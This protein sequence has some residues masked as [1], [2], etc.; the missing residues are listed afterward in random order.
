VKIAVVGPGLSGKSGAVWTDDVWERP[1]VPCDRIVLVLDGQPRRVERNE[2]FIARVAAHRKPG[3]VVIAKTDLPS[4]NVRET[5]ALL[6]GTAIEAW[7]RYETGPS[8]LGVF[9]E[10]LE[11]LVE[12]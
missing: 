8:S 1:L 12:T 7:R 10:A 4:C 2:H 3:V 5:K 6:A 11:G 9:T